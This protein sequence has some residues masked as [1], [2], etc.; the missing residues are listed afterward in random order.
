[1]C[2]RRDHLIAF[3]LTYANLAIIP[4]I[5]TVDCERDYYSITW[6]DLLTTPLT[7]IWHNILIFLRKNPDKISDLLEAIVCQIIFITVNSIL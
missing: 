4:L 7:A 1:M 5:T 2:G 6:P 3:R